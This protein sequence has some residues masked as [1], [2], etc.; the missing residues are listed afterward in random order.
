M[1]F[2]EG[3]RVVYIGHNHACPHS[4][5]RSVMFAPFGTR[6]VVESLDSDGQNLDVT[7]DRLG[8]NFNWMRTHTML[9]EKFDAVLV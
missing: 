2:S 8:T 3:D 9:E 1:S 7:V 5:C 6:G 4:D